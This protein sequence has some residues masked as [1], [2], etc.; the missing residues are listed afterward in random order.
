MNEERCLVL[1]V[2]Y[3]EKGR[4]KTRLGRSL[5][6]DMVVRLY[7]AFIEDL[8]GKLTQG[9]YRFRI[10]VH[11]RERISDF[12]REFGDA[13]SYMSQTGPDLGGKMLNAFKQCFSDG[14]RSVIVMGSDIPDVPKRIIEEA[15][16]ALEKNGAV[17]GPTYDGGYYLIGFSRESFFPAVFEGIMWG[18]DGVFGKTVQIMERAGG[19]FRVLPHWRD[20][21]RPE[22]IAALVDNSGT[23]DFSGSKTMACLRD[24]GL[25]PRSAE[26]YPI[27]PR[28]SI[29][30]PVINEEAVINSALDHVGNIRAGASVEIIV[31][32]G[33][34]EGSTIRAIRDGHVKT[35]VGKRGRGRQMNR[36]AALAR[37]DILIFLHADTRLPSGAFGFIDRA[38]RDPA[39]PAGAFDLSI[40]NR[41]PVYRMLAGIASC[42]SRL[43]RIPYGDQAFFFRRDYF[44][45]MGGFSDIPLMED[46]EIMRRLK[47]RGAGIAII[48]RPVTTSARRWE[49]EG[50]IKCTLRNWLLISLYL[51]G[52]SPE[53]LAKFYK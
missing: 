14:C 21:D 27:A 43:T 28:F 39:R 16:R 23:T 26:S 33:D 38:L 52:A 20:I 30:I 17:I 49:K 24:Y 44:H 13:F 9:D 29:I 10:A 18:G 2:K 7:R 45:A 11:P 4:V 25:A 8:I 40:A 32:D 15:F 42:R 35:A 1:F 31:V 46:V 3:P 47:R 51:A 12:R 5:D 34:P 36:G 50:I 48:D 19:R 37:G 53:R 6:E 41:R 22:D